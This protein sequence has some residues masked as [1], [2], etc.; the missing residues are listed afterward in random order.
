[1]HEKTPQ[2]HSCE[3]VGEGTPSKGAYQ[4][5]MTPIAKDNCSHAR[6]FG[7]HTMERSSCERSDDIAA[8]GCGTRVFLDTVFG[9]GLARRRV[10]HHCRL[11]P[12][13]PHKHLLQ[14]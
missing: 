4:S 8:F 13:R 5:Q 7:R 14:G 11:H 9:R 12:R 3:H 10:S 2:G 1:M 6:G